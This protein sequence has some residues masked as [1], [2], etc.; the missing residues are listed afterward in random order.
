MLVTYDPAQGTESILYTFDT[1]W[2]SGHLWNPIGKM[3]VTD[4]TLFGLTASGGDSFD[5]TAFQYFLNGN[6]IIQR[7]GFFDT[8]GEFPQ[9]I[10]LASNN[11]AY[12]VTYAG[13]HGT[14][15]FGVLF[16]YDINTFKRYDEYS[17]D[18]IVNGA[19]PDGNL[20]QAANGLIYG[21]TPVGG[22]Y[23]KG[24]L[25]QF[26]PVAQ[27]YSKLYDFKGGADGDHPSG[28]VIRG[29]DGLLYG[30]TQ[31]GGTG[32][33]GM[34][35]AFDSMSGTAINLHQFTAPVDSPTYLYLAKN[36]IFYGLTQ[37]GSGSLFEYNPYNNNFS[38]IQQF[39]ASDS[40]GAAPFPSIAETP[41]GTLIIRTTTGGAAGYGRLSQFNPQYAKVKT[42][43][44]ANGLS[45]NQITTLALDPSNCETLGYIGTAD[46]NI[47]SVDTTG[48]VKIVNV[49]PNGLQNV[50]A[51]GTG[52]YL[53]PQPASSQLQFVFSRSIEQ[54]TLTVIDLYGQQL[55]QYKLN[56]QNLLTAD[57]LR[58]APGMYFF[59]LEEGGR[60]FSTGKISVAR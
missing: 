54:G 51:A 49:T 20:M 50:S 4:T 40:A 48:T 23:N 38:T 8:I 47:S 60:I 39:N 57:I 9:G 28:P 16:R 44:T 19:H 29:T 10:I 58:L 18:S 1:T 15:T 17:F 33:G 45:S 13:G 36:G 6:Y 34:L 56:N 21:S 41:Q 30:T 52:V 32:N 11:L 24:T 42:Y 12:G 3:I 37:G 35:F 55:Q 26:D 46:G 31:F 2:G 59:S 27:A 43:T 5:G 25:F 53:Y 7:T 22:A 14:D